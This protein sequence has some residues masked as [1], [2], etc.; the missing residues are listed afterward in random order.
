M[1][2]RKMEKEKIVEELKKAGYKS[3]ITDSIVYIYYQK[4]I[5]NLKAFTSEVKSFLEKK[6]YNQSF[7]FAVEKKKTFEGE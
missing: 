2:G 7:G 3:D 1:R 4:G 5:E 6:G